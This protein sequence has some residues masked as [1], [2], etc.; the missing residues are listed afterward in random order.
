MG[1]AV[2]LYLRGYRRS[3]GI[4]DPRR[5][6]LHID[7]A[8]P[9]PVDHIFCR[10]HSQSL[11]PFVGVVRIRTLLITLLLVVRRIHIQPAFILDCSRV[12]SEVEVDKRVGKCLFKFRSS[13]PVC[14]QDGFGCLLLC[15]GGQCGCEGEEYWA[16]HKC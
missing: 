7:D 13:C 12:S 4:V 10:H 9:G 14:G 8:V 16:F 2:F 15:A 6:F 1:L 3:P 5:Q 11:D